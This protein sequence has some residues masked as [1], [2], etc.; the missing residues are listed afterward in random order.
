MLVKS[1]SWV[2]PMGHHAIDNDAATMMRKNIVMMS[3]L[4]ASPFLPSLLLPLLVLSF[5]SSPVQFRHEPLYFMNCTKYNLSLRHSG[6][7]LQHKQAYFESKTSTEPVILRALHMGMGALSGVK[8]RSCE[9]MTK[10][11]TR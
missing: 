3:T 1:E 10:K 4:P 6:S 8:R 7:P 11:A 2:P 5:P 9:S